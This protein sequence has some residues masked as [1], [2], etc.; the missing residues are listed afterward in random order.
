MWRPMQVCLAYKADGGRTVAVLSSRPK[1]EMEAIFASA[2]P[3]AKRQASRFLFR[4]VRRAA[5]VLAVLIMGW[6]GAGMPGIALQ[7]AIGGGDAGAC[8]P[9]ASQ[10]SLTP[11]PMWS[12]Y[13]FGMHVERREQ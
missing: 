7:P 6:Q 8:L 5:L 4:Q 9:A 11:S 2:I 12:S 10:H 13:T 3:L 1:L